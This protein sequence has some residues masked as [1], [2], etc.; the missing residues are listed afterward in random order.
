MSR[1]GK[2][3]IEV[4]ETVSIQIQPKNI[5]IKGRYG[6]LERKIDDILECTLSEN[7]IS[8]QRKNDEKKSKA[9]HGLMRALINNMIVG[10]DKKFVKTLIAEGVGYKFQVEKKLLTLNM[11]YTHPIQ[12]L[13]PMDLD[14]KLESSTK[15]SI[16][17]IDK[18]KV[19][20]LA[21]KIRE[22]RPPE[23]YKGKGIMYEGEKIIRKAGKTGK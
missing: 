12:F 17:G 11:G 14:V 8:I 23:P 10:V 13:I 15:I 21:A 22:I 19:G 9:Y 4:P 5:I 16:T 18:E 20:F 2:K 7:K 6:I 1:I 3:Q